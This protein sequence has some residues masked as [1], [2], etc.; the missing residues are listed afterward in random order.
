MLK[1]ASSPSDKMTSRPRVFMNRS[2]LAMKL[3][4]SAFACL[5]LAGFPADTALHAAPSAEGIDFFEKRIRPLL[6]EKCY[7]CHTEGKKVK[8]GLSLDYREALQRGGDSGA[9]IV[10]GDPEK[11]KL[12]EAVRYQNRDLQMPPKG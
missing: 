6:V 5:F 10:A 4:S 7:E 1:F 12:I 2:K 8:G 3:R 9:S 11:S